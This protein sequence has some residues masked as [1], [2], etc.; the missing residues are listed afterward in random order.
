M[1]FMRIRVSATGGG[2]VQSASSD[3]KKDPALK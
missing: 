3:P 1:R 2:L